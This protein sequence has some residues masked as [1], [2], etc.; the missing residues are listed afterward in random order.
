MTRSITRRL[1]IAAPL[2]VAVA[3]TA[4]FT[5]APGGSD[6]ATRRAQT[7][8]LLAVDQACAGVDA[9]GRADHL[10]ALTSCA[11]TLRQVA[12]GAPAGQVSR[13]CTYLGSEAAGD[14]CVATV[15]LRRG[16]LRVSGPLSHTDAR[17]T[18]V[19]AGG[20]GPYAG[21]RG[22]VAVRQIDDDR[23]EATIRLLP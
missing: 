12:G 10:G 1:A 13:L 8:S 19:I 21:A 20:T 6:A 17:S 11:S 2:T 23:T 5:L 15:R 16:T 9:G 4:A 7:L 14:D 18:W 22:T 3:A